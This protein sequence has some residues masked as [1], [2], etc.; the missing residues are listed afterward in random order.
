MELII[1]GTLTTIAL[2]GMQA[3]EFL[4]SRHAATSTAEPLEAVADL[5]AGVA[6]DAA[7][8]LARQDNEESLVKAA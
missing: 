7:Q 8:A 1:I 4:R 6:A 5:T 3:A 2:M